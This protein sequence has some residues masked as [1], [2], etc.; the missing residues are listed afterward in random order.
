MMTGDRWNRIKEIFGGALDRPREERT[1]YLDEACGGDADTRAAVES[2]LAS[3]DPDTDFLEPPCEGEA[4]RLLGDVATGLDEGRQVGRYR[5]IEL[6]ASGGM[7]HVYRATRDDDQYRKQVAVK[8]VKRGVDTE[9]VLRRFRR[10]RQTLATLDHPHIARLIDGGTTDDGRPFLVME[11][12]DGSPIDRYCDQ[13]SL[14]IP[15]RLSLFRDACSAVQH[16]HRNLVVHRDLKPGNI[17]VDKQ[18]VLK[19]LDF[20]ISKLLDAGSRGQADKTTVSSLRIMT[21]R[22]AS[23]EQIRGE[24]ITTAG[25][26][27]SLGVV[28]YELLTGHS[29]YG[30]DTT[31]RKDLE[32]HVLDTDPDRPS[33]AVQ[34]TAELVSPDGSTQRITPESVSRARKTSA[35]KLQRRLR[36]D[37]DTIVMTALQK[38]PQRR[39]PSVD[40]FSEDIRRYLAGLPVS[41][42]PDTWTYRAGKFV[43]R[44]KAGVL[45]VAIAVV[46]LLGGTIAATVGLLEAR[47]ARA[48]AVAEAERAQTEAKTAERVNEFLRKV[49]VFTDPSREGRNITVRE[50]LDKAA[51]EVETDFAEE[52]DIRA[53]LH[54]VI[55]SSYCSIA[56]YDAAEAH[57]R[58]A[59]RIHQRIH[60]EDQLVV[61]DDLSALGEL[62]L[63][64]GDYAAAEGELRK[65]LAIFRDEVGVED[66][67]YI[68]SLNNLGMAL[69]E[70]GDYAGAETVTRE[71]LEI[72][73]NIPDAGRRVIAVSLENLATLR[74]ILG[75]HDEAESLCREAV[76]TWREL[77]GG[78]DLSVGISLNELG[79]ILKAKGDYS[80]A[81]SAYRESLRIHS[82]VLG[83]EHPHTGTI[84]NNLGTLLQAKGDYP[85]AEALLRQALEVRRNSLGPK[86]PAVA[87]TLNNLGMLL[88]E[89]GDYA[90]AEP[91]LQ[92][93]LAVRREVL[94]DKHPDLAQ[95]LNNLAMVLERGGNLDAAEQLYREALAI[96]RSS[97]GDEH[98]VVAT[99]LN[100]LGVLLDKRGDG[101]EA[102]SLLRESLAIRRQAL[103]DEH[104]QVA[105]TMTNLASVLQ[106]MDRFDE[107][108]SLLIEAATVIRKQVGD[109]HPQL[110]FTL[111]TLAGGYGLQTKF[112]LAEPLLRQV[113][114]IRRA[115]YPE[116]HWRVADAE[117][118]L[119][120]CL[121]KLQ[122]YEEAEP[123]LIEGFLSIKASR[124][125]AD[126]R[127]QAALRRLVALYD[128]WGKPDEAAEWRAKLPTT[129]PAP[130]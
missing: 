5:L 79:L 63:S 31:T 126:E 35:E 80:E 70:M 93:A 115:T 27:Y 42:R 89:R 48:E 14:S 101:S 99:M 67:A 46:S 22:Y 109:K 62:L 77:R 100:N 118:T 82:E 3:D 83:E 7:G 116:E 129:Q 9:E 117:S 96:W 51:A 108:E 41:A 71:G 69:K 112:D 120:S 91:L 119:G 55:G 23:P 34:R 76:A 102:E 47:D 53:G 75:D 122:R 113:L 90:A 60:G 104:V 13:G 81:E 56:A 11:Y 44:N 33:T 43:R 19:L 64:R 73:R 85:A 4:V 32:R 124:G 103:G 121:T 20:G 72:A 18:G 57:L 123:L 128:A 17:L 6:I 98:P 28:L 39:Y 87:Q 24:P 52:A 105:Q 114:E 38:D 10:E 36:G 8:I 21:P 125:P 12:V 74:G 107:S 130:Q 15:N 92:E 61:A 106:D 94:D 66:E 84:L 111:N 1:A 2:L 68:L 49:L 110:A 65:A 86:H 29:P 95:S 25:D 127:V 45:G 26:I 97:V 54:A 40:Q 88:A 16:A 58:S 30:D 37:L 78:D 59:L 50:L